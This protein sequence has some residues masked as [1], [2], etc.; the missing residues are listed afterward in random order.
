[1]KILV[2]DD[3]GFVRELMAAML[4][5][6]GYNVTMCPGVDAAIAVLDE[7]AFDLIITDL[8][9]PQKTGMDFITYLRRN[10]ITVPVLAVTAGI[11]NA[12]DDYVNI[13]ELYADM[14]LA[15]PVSRDTLL[16]SV[17]RLIEEG[18]KRAEA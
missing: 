11:E 12:T 14:A 2:V 15:K 3:D 9:M 6:V 10:K 16:V 7:Y 17:E 4:E 8:V 13:G 1:M 18:R 5:P